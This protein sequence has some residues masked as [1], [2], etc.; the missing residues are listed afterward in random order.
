VQ[1]AH[2]IP[3]LLREREIIHDDAI[4][5]ADISVVGQFG[6]TIAQTL[7]VQSCRV[8]LRC[9]LRKTVCLAGVNTKLSR[10]DG[11]VF[12][13]YLKTRLPRS[14]TGEH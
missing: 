10:I 2:S 11:N 8:N 4:V 12:N 14:V 7:S 13:G 1:R 3:T 5:V 6:T 9:E